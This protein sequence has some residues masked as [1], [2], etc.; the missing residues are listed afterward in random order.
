MNRYSPGCRNVTVVVRVAP[1]GT[2]HLLGPGR[3]GPARCRFGGGRGSASSPTIHSW[4]MGSSLTSTT[5]TGCPGRHDHLGPGERRVAHPDL[6]PVAGASAS[7]SGP[8]TQARAM[9]A[10][11]S[12][13]RT[14]PTSA[15]RADARRRITRG[16]HPRRCPAGRSADE[17]Q[18]A[19]HATDDERHHRQPSG[20][21]RRRSGRRAR[22]VQPGIDPG[23][24][25]GT[26][27]IDGQV[28]LELRRLGVDGHLGQPRRLAAPTPS[29]GRSAGRRGAPS[30]ARPEW[31]SARPLNPSGTG[32]SDGAR[33]VSR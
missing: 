25:T 9:P 29:R 13:S 22:H 23:R 12:V 33:S 31:S 17:Q 21:P 18:H 19:A 2:R 8:P 5:V 15:A 14:P 30:D 1:A 26:G 4:S 10:A 32:S 3:R 24:R 6:D 27:R 20:S 28:E 7:A 16:G 11:P